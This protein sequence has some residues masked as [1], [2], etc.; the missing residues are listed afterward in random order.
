LNAL[1]GWD[2]LPTS[3][4]PLTAIPTFLRWGADYRVRIAFSEERPDEVVE[5][6][7]PRDVTETLENFVT[8]EA[9]PKNRLGVLQ[10]E[11]SCPAPLLAR[12]LVLID[13]PGIGSTYQHNTETTLNFLPQCDAALFLV[14]ADPPVTEVELEFLKEVR[15]NISRLFFL[16]NK[17]D[18]LEDE[19]R[20]SSFRRWGWTRRFRF[21]LFRPGM[22]WLPV[23]GGMRRD[24]G[25]R[26]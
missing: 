2:L 26:V 4:I 15:R 17:V 21:S 10:A 11:V 12:G 9:N 13:T 14:S 1:L 3:V 6:A 24:S 23:S 18:Y 5:A 25:P 22:G 8:E 20:R 7:G 16:F 19:D